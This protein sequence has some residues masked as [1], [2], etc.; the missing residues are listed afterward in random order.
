VAPGESIDLGKL[1][2]RVQRG[3]T[4]GAGVTRSAASLAEAG[5][6][7]DEAAAALAA[8]AAAG[9]GPA[10]GEL[11]NL[12]TVGRALLCSA[13]AREESRGAHSRSDFPATDPRWRCRLVHGARVPGT[14]G[15]DAAVPDAAPAAVP[16][17]APAAG[18]GAAVSGSGRAGRRAGP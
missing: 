8:G 5:A 16:D 3:L 18:P 4:E 13:V 15:R 9:T 10:A 1:R 7:L 2:D 17:A 12:L 6:V 14:G 11:A